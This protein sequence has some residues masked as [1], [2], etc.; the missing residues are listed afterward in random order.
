MRWLSKVCSMQASYDRDQVE[1]ICCEGEV[2]S[3]HGEAAGDK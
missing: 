2:M 3:S 1:A